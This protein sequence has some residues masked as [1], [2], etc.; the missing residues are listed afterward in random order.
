M[1]PITIGCYLW[2]KNMTITSTDI[3][4]QRWCP[5]WT[6]PEWAPS[7]VFL[8]RLQFMRGADDG[9]DNPAQ[10]AAVYSSDKES[11]VTGIAG[12]L[13]ADDAA[14]KQPLNGSADIA[15]GKMGQS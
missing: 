15:A 6:C 5:K 10:V 1:R 14:A 11:A 3:I 7:G 2:E 9:T 13:L 4:G 8:N 12:A